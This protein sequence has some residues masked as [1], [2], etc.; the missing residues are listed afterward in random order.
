MH[1]LAFHTS[2][3]IGG[4][5]REL[6]LH[7]GAISYV[8]MVVRK[9]AQPKWFGAPRTVAVTS[10]RTMHAMQD[11]ACRP[12]GVTAGTFLILDGG[13]RGWPRQVVWI[14]RSKDHLLLS[15]SLTRIHIV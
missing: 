8:F 11:A 5:A 12:G 1:D 2:T 14:A 9:D 15:A 3:Q 13:I 7:E 10:I 6:L 4:V